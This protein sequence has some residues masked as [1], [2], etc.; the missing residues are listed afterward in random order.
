M[1]WW[2][3]KEREDDLD[4]ELRDHLEIEAHE[5]QEEGFS[6]EEARLV[7]RRLFG[8]A[9]LVKEEVREMWGWMWLDRL[10]MDLRY[11]GRGLCRSPVFTLVAV[12][13]L[14][15]GIGAT[16]TVF[17]GFEAVFFNAVTAKDVGRLKQV[18]IGGQ[19]FSYPY[20]E[21]LSAG[22]PMLT[23]VAA[24]DQTSVSFRSGNDL[25]KTTADRFSTAEWCRRNDRMGR[26]I[27]H[28]RPAV[29]LPVRTLPVS[30]IEPAFR[31]PLV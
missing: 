3:R 14:A 9:T 29:P 19:R 24:Y 12:L 1:T 11:G 15:L 28:A 10:W 27:R 16:V 17:S 8:N 31:T 5:R 23:G 21:E 2:R 20:Y 7:A 4:R 6:P 26:L 25:E 30:M 22:T 18:E 13:S